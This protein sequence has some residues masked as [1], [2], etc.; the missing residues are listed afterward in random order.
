MSEGERQLE[1]EVD[2]DVDVAEDPVGEPTTDDGGGGFRTKLRAGAGKI[3]SAR[4]LV[5]ALL[6]VAVTAVLAEGLVPLGIVG[7]LLGI[8]VA[9]FVY[10]T[11]S[12]A[13]RYL[14]LGLA[15]GVVG[16][17]L[18]FVGNLVIS[19]FGPGVP[20][21]AVG[22]AAGGV[23]GVLGHYFGRDLRDGLTREV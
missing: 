16:G 21:V 10:G 5:L 15:G 2:L 1:R 9:A 18:A 20:L 11:L 4:A 23:A 17:G 12:G 19:L 6:V 8:F 7:N 14:E 22:F 3:V 13:G